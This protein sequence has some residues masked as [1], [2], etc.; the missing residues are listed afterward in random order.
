M[1]TVVKIRCETVTVFLS[2]CHLSKGGKSHSSRQA[3]GP[4]HLLLEPASRSGESMVLTRPAFVQ[5]NSAVGPLWENRTRLCP[6]SLA[7]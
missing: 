7:L 2:L 6:E 4:V 3:L 1:E 5:A